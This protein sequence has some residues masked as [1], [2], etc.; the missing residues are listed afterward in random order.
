M[1][2]PM[3][4]ALNLLDLASLSVGCPTGDTPHRWTDQEKDRLMTA[5]K[6]M[7]D[8]EIQI[9]QTP[10]GDHPGSHPRA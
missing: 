7:A 9:R 10:A 6:E 4:S 8:L 2:T 1:L 5:F 3:T